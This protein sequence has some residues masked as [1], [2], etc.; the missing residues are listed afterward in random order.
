MCYHVVFSYGV[1]VVCHFVIE[2]ELL[3]N[4]FFFQ[5]TNKELLLNNTF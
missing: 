1:F 4:F 3:V 2:V 5:A